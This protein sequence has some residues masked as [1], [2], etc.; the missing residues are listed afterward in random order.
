MKHVKSINEMF[1][2]NKSE[3]DLKNSL[4]KKYKDFFKDND[5]EENEYSYAKDSEELIEKWEDH[6]SKRMYSLMMSDVSNRNSFESVKKNFNYINLLIDSNRLDSEEIIKDN[7]EIFSSDPFPIVKGNDLWTV[8]VEDKKEKEIE[9]L[10]EDETSKLFKSNVNDSDFSILM[11]SLNENFD[12]PILKPYKK[13]L[14]EFVKKN[15]DTKK[16]ELYNALISLNLI[17]STN[18][19]FLEFLQYDNIED[20]RVEELNQEKEKGKRFKKIKKVLPVTAPIVA[21]KFSNKK[22]SNDRFNNKLEKYINNLHPKVQDRFR[23]F[24]KEVENMGYRIV[25]TSGYRDFFKQSQLKNKNKK[26]ASP[27]HSPHNYGIAMDLNIVGPDGTWYKK[28][29][30]KSKWEETGIPQLGKSL[31]F[32]WGGDFKTYHDPIHFDL[33]KE[34]SVSQMRKKAIEESGQD[35]TDDI[36][37]SKVHG[38]KVNIA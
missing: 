12:R 5:I 32:R 11:E 2:L 13:L 20:F 34:Y 14:K 30:P 3:K 23:Y 21:R 37:W 10:V 7:D 15:R 24:F 19:K 31:G 8:L 9:D 22:E 25:P 35:I 1:G 26:N 36:D 29:T 4:M 38:N 6:L 28:A 17:T 18:L 27:G 33:A 16:S